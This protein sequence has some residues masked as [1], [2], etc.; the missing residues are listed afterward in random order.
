ML[1]ADIRKLKDKIKY[2]PLELGAMHPGAEKK[3]HQ[4]CI[5]I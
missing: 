5:S 1:E 2:R 4:K 3:I